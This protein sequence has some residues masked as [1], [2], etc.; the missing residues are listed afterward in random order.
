MSKNSRK[1]VMRYGFSPRSVS[2][3]IK[4]ARTIADIAGS[5]NILPEHMSESIAYHKLCAN[6]VLEL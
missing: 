4:V 5:T 2:S 1:G 6:M 3:C